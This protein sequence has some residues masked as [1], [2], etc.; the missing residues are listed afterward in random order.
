MPTTIVEVIR[1]MARTSGK[2]AKD[3][4]RELGKPYSTFMR[5]RVIR[6]VQEDFLAYTQKA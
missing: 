5:E 1:P 3:L 2:P 4:A 6:Q